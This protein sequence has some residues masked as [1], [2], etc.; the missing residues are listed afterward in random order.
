MSS[1]P[2]E[3]ILFVDD[4]A[5]ALD[6][7]RRQLRN[8]YHIFSADSAQKALELIK[9]EGPF[10]VIVSDRFMPEM[11]GIQ[12]FLHVQNISPDST[13]IMM[14]GDTQ[15]ETALQA[16]NEGQVFRFLAKP[17]SQKILQAAIESGLEQYRLVTSHKVL[18]S[19]TLQGSIRVLTNMLSLVNRGAYAHSERVK[20][21]A[22]V[23]AK[24]MNITSVWQLEV[25]ATLS[26]I[27][28]VKV[29]SSIIKKK[30]NGYMLSL[31]EEELYQTYPQV[32]HDLI[33]NIPRLDHIA[34]T[35][36]Y[37][38][39]NFDGSG[40]P[41]GPVC[42]QDIPIESRIIKA[43]SA[44]VNW[45]D[46]NCKPAG[47]LQRLKNPAHF[48]PDVI[49]AMEVVLH[50]QKR[51]PVSKSLK[52]R[53]A[54]LQPGMIIAKD[55]RSIDGFALLLKKD[56]ELTEALLQQVQN[57]HKQNPVVDIIEIHNHEQPRAEEL[58]S[59]SLP[60]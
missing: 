30:M 40:F 39:K 20:T 19:Q 11:D 48:D 29:P 59:E 12:F 31:E 41:E 24:E 32:G 45:L 6:A 8:G 57:Y 43:A 42:G 58:L 38:E 4:E 53:L 9:S 21:L 1:I 52:V 27:G 37:Q 7:I 22:S 55:V 54:D 25:A 14:T 60:V 26:L 36:L 51:K 10:G 13:R 23:I 5:M 56:Q 15:Y 2:P 3:K 33:A 50:L 34:K 47:A 17:C 44:F 28:Y 16:V 46:R 35:V 18:L 49:N